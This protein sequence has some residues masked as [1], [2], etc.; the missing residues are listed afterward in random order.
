M[1]WVVAFWVGAL[2]VFVSYVGYGLWLAALARLRPRPSRVEYRPDAEAPAVT[3]VMAAANEASLISRKIDAVLAQDYPPSRLTVL[4]VSDASTDGTD[5]IVAARA[6]QDPRIRLL[7]SGARRGKP[8]ALNLARPHIGSD[9]AVLM[10]VRQ[11][12]TPC[13][14]RELVAHLADP[15]VGAV[16]GDLR[17]RGD[18]YWTYE[19]F[20]RRRESRSGSMVQ[21]TGSL[22]AVRTAD[23]PSIPPDTILDDVYVPLTIALR[24]RRIVMAEGAGSIDV[25]TRSVGHEFVRKVRTLAGLVQICHRVPG[26][27]SPVRNPVWARFVVH[28][29]SRLVCPYALASMLAAAWLAPGWPYRFALGGAIAV[30]FLSTVRL[31]L[32]SRFCSVSRSL[33]ALNVAAFWAVPSYYLGLV[34]VTW[35]R[36]DTDRT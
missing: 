35:A 7:R 10:D 22:Y 3:C 17:V 9:I 21:V 13:A 16:S 15:E 25:V 20:V 19:A 5:A 8:S 12:L 32:V 24:G 11:E 29:L 28:K 34:S 4:V 2:I 23:L 36:V 26:C 14:I 30:A 31:P 1:I 18:A 33:I 6:A 27:L